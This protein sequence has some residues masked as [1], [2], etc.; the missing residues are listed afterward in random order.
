MS[1][2]DD[3]QGEAIATMVDVAFA[4]RGRT[5]PREHGPALAQALLQRAPWLAAEPDCA[6]HRV[7]VAAG[8]AA[9]A[10]LPQRAR[11]LLRVPRERVAALLVLEGAVLDV[12]GHQLQLGAPRVHEL[13][14]HATLYAALVASDAEADEAA[15]LRTMAGELAALEVHGRC[16][17]GL[18][19]QRRDDD[20]PL[21]GF[22][23][24]LDGLTPAHS[25]R[26]QQR[27]LGPHRLMGCGVFVPHRSAAALHGAPMA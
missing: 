18:R 2:A 8:T 6:V 25:L 12:A 3:A 15:F 5:L 24:M 26:L 21:D 27:G 11:L 22:S 20:A 1:T 23:L 13:L 17:C 19:R 10:L 7:K 16:I 9:E 4:L 14:A